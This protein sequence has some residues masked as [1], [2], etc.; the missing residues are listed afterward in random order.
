MGVHSEVFKVPASGGRP[1]QLTNGNHAVT[2]W[3]LESNGTQMLHDERHVE[4]RRRFT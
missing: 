1:E 3:T 4:P 2:G